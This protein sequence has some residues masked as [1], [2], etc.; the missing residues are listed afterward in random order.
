MSRIPNDITPVILE[1]D[2][3][4]KAAGV[5]PLG[6]PMNAIIKFGQRFNMSMPFTEPQPGV[7][8]HLISSWKY[9]AKIRDWYGQ[10]YGDGIKLD[11][12][13]NAK[14]AVQADGDLWELK[15]PII[16]GRFTPVVERELYDDHDA[17]VGAPR[18]NAC[19]QLSGI[20]A[21]RL[22]HF[23]DND[24]AEVYGMFMVGMDVRAAFDRFSK[25]SHFFAEAQSDWMT[26][27]MHMTSQKPNH[28]QARWASLQ[29]AEKFMKGLIE[30]IGDVSPIPHTHD[31][32]KLHKKLASSI[33]GLDLDRLLNDIQ[34]SA[35][36]RY[37]E[38]ASTREQSYS[39][40][41]SSLLLVRAL[42]S[43]RNVN[44]SS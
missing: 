6:R 44:T 33:M 37:G 10:V 26:A 38:E 4:L 12:S 9:A 32:K 8:D 35:A 30:V 28:G 16:Y 13:A 27:V 23:S 18:L 36:V 41:K 39:A 21:A 34:C 3:E 20:T 1:I 2:N 29:L 43:V 24:L 31:L 42:G 25:S 19:K 7:P 40:H 22:N 15:L 14:V 17:V 11:P 5:P